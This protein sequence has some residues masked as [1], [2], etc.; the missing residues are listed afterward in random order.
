[1]AT[2][3]QVERTA[4]PFLEGLV[5]HRLH[6]RQFLEMI[7][8]G[9]FP[10]N[11]EIQLIAGLT[12]TMRPNRASPFLDGIP[13]YRFKIAQFDKMIG[14]DIFPEGVRV[15]LLGGVLAEK[16]T[17]YPPHNFAVG[18][19]GKIL[20]NLLTGDWVVR[21][22]KSVVLREDWRPEADL[23]VV[24][25]PEDRYRVSDPGL[26]DLV[27]IIEVAESSR[28]VDRGAKR[29][30][31]AAA[32]I[33]VYWVVDLSRR[34]VE[35]HSLPSGVGRRARYRRI[36]VFEADAEVSVVI[37]GRELGKIAVREILP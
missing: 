2:Q 37:E 16:M 4:A 28:S 13:L 27:L 32:G 34:V 17:K 35:V 15:E 24:R 23:A 1:M 6:G 9:V 10:R 18:R 36:D 20:R 22:E 8:A 11:A 26:A 14:A 12:A 31:Y 19:L 3:T 21:E 5:P 7:R 33:P 29:H 25:G 30:G